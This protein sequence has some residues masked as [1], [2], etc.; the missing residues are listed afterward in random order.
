MS[1]PTAAALAAL[2]RRLRRV[3]A[4]LGLTHRIRATPGLNGWG[5]FSTSIDTN[6][7]PHRIGAT[8]FGE[9]SVTLSFTVDTETARRIVEAYEALISEA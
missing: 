9:D 4:P 6:T 2:T 3:F 5:G 7:G 1:Y 8:V